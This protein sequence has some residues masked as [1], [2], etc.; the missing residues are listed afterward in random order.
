LNDTTAVLGIQFWAAASLEFLITFGEK[1]QD[2]I[3]SV[4]EI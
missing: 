1:W 4:L 3:S 2:G